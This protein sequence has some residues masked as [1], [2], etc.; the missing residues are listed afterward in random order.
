MFYIL[1]YKK[2]T[3]FRKWSFTIVVKKIPALIQGQGGGE[4]EKLCASVTESLQ[5]INT[6]FQ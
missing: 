4:E 1:S 2:Q 5:K 6:S 3:I